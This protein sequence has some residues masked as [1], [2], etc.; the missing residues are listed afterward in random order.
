[1]DSDTSSKAIIGAAMSVH[2]ALG[3]G[4]LESTYRACLAHELH[5]LGLC[6]RTEVP[7]PVAYKGVQLD[8]GYRLDLLVEEIIIVELKVV[9]KLLRIHEAQL[10]AYL[11][12]S[13]LQVGLLINFHVPHLRLGIK[14][15]VNNYKSIEVPS[16]QLQE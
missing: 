6:V 5:L 15:M 7:L 12:L 3:P 10:L 8:I 14:R 13:G 1:M 2:S 9:E 16:G 11:K 4:L